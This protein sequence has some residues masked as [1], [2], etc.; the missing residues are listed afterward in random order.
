[1]RLH[2][3]RLENYKAVAQREV[4]FPD[5]GVVVIAGRNEIGKSS[6]IEAFDL[7]MSTRHTST[8][9]KVRAAQP[10]G[11]DLGVTVEAELTIA[12]ER[13][14]ITR[15]W[16]KKTS[17]KV[18][19]ISGRRKGRVLTGDQ[20]C[21]ALSQLWGSNDVTLWDA[22]RL[23]QATGLEQQALNGSTSLSR[24][25]QVAAGAESI[26]A[27]GSRDLLEAVRAEVDRYYTAATRSPNSEHKQVL[28]AVEEAKLARDLAAGR[29]RALEATRAEL[30]TATAQGADSRRKLA[31][32]EAEFNELAVQR[33]QVDAA[34][35]SEEQARHVRDAA[36][37]TGRHAA[38]ELQHRTDLVEKLGTTEDQLA[39]LRASQIKLAADLAP[40]SA[41]VQAA[42]QAYELAQQA[43]QLA[44]DEVECA[45]SDR[46]HLVRR[47]DL[48]RA[49]ARLDRLVQLTEQVDRLTAA[50][51]SPLTAEL[52]GQL[53]AAE[54]EV[55]ACQARLEVG[56]AQLAIT[57]LGA[58]TPLLVDGQPCD[59]AG[60]RPLRQPITRPIRVELP[61]QWLIELV[62]PQVDEL[63]TAASEAGS[64]RAALLDQAQVADIAQARQQWSELVQVS[65]ELNQA[66][67]SRDEVAGGSTAAELRAEID[68]LQAE[69]DE[70]DEQRLATVSSPADPAAADRQ[71]K[72]AMQARDLARQVQ[73][74]TAADYRICADDLGRLRKQFDDVESRLQL[75]AEHA[76]QAAA[77]LQAERDRVS[78]DELASAAEAAV[79]DLAAAET[80]LADHS[81]FLADLDAERVL[82]RSAAADQEVVDL[83]QKV[84][85]A[86]EHRSA[87]LGQLRGM[88]AD[89]CQREA[90]Q[91]AT[92]YA[93]ASW[94]AESLGRRARAA[95]RLETELLAH[96]RDAT[97]CYVEPFRAA[98]VEL[99]RVTYADPDFDVLVS[100]ELQVTARY[101]AGEWIDFDALS[102]GAKEQL[103]ILIRLATAQLV[104]PDDHV[105]VLLDDALGYSDQ[106]RL[107]RMWSALGQAG[108][109]S[110]VI[111][112]TAN[113][114]RYAGVGQLARIDLA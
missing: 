2:R 94:A 46:D 40:A 108:R 110:Q 53:E 67:R 105:P 72:A 41:R 104:N 30:E 93:E 18:R 96:Q 55:A 95:L 78:D 80:A 99:G 36:V 92:A 86:R 10:V 63:R 69:I 34:L 66:S 83:R 3:L 39:E 89:R 19:F 59:P 26:D 14:V 27:E 60:D 9:A 17:T 57:A 50:A 6:M 13:V 54:A 77:A 38:T 75:V 42:E 5:A 68:Q 90:D 58:P 33:A 87:L 29:L 1:M 44:D 28:R 35:Q 16:L 114:E 11:S 23:M 15:T 51:E 107:R 21:D 97:Q 73:Q 106:P 79:A 37:V 85:T 70:Y 31:V 113:P 32:A 91:T 84:A 74:Q 48:V 22:L 98:I 56:S 71:V 25:L 12:D 101:L 4:C 100:P 112:M 109:K 43:A 103:V 111:V 81:Q 45:R 49:A 61:G 82:E 7:L 24:A 8:S 47:A 64:R 20:A 102:T 62:P 88:D 52:I 76:Q 65:A